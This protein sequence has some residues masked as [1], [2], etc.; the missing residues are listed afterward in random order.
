MLV[1]IR[2]AVKRFA[3]LAVIFWK[4]LSAFLWVFETSLF[5]KL[6]CGGPGQRL[7]GMGF[8]CFNLS[9]GAGTLK[10]F[11]HVWANQT[12]V[13][14]VSNLVS[15]REPRRLMNLMHSR[16]TPKRYN[17]STRFRSFPKFGLLLTPVAGGFM[18]EYGLDAHWNF[19]RSTG[20]FYNADQD[21]AMP[22]EFLVP[23]Q[24]GWQVWP[25]WRDV[26]C[27]CTRIEARVFNFSNILDKK[28][29]RKW[30]QPSCQGECNLLHEPQHQPKSDQ[31]LDLQFWAMS[32]SRELRRVQ[33]LVELFHF[34]FGYVWPKGSIWWL[35]KTKKVWG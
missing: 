13:V 24:A 17:K 19:A 14:Q 10:L 30:H 8:G 6:L 9:P 15:F 2:S 16:H 29:W 31:S 20:R 23:K 26:S 21:G 11:Q 18:A 33:Y 7:I 12:A 32:R 28:S 5:C 27:F 35:N 1:G 4:W 22:Q 3:N 25:S 34:F